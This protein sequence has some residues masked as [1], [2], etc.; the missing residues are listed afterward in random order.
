MKTLTESAYYDGIFS[1]VGSMCSKSTS[2]GELAGCECASGL[3]EL[4]PP[5]G[6]HQ[7]HHQQLPRSLLI[8]TGPGAPFIA[9]NLRV[10]RTGGPAAGAVVK[11]QTICSTAKANTSRCT[12]TELPAC[13]P[14]ARARSRFP[15]R[16]A[17]HS[18]RA[19]GSSG[20]ASL[21][22]HRRQ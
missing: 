3:S 19:R 7:T 22:R 11:A 1:M 14:A 10:C 15:S 9:D 21:Q 5:V 20:G 4:C 13:P 12:S 2:V 6:H 17:Y 8:E 16:H 18:A